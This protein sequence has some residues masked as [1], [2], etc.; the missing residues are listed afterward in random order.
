MCIFFIMCLKTHRKKST[1][2]GTLRLTL[3]AF[4]SDCHFFCFPVRIAGQSDCSCVNILTMSFGETY[5]EHKTNKSSFST[6]C[7]FWQA[8]KEKLHQ[9]C[10]LYMGQA[11]SFSCWCWGNSDLHYENS[12]KYHSAPCTFP[13]C[14]QQLIP[15]NTFA[16]LAQIVYCLVHSILFKVSLLLPPN[17]EVFY[18]LFQNYQI[19][20][21]YGVIYISPL[22]ITDLLLFHIFSWSMSLT[23]SSVYIHWCPDLTFS[24]YRIFHRTFYCIVL[25]FSIFT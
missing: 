8:R 18:F 6:S 9:N 15:V 16:W 5:R 1:T 17:L 3:Q 12:F 24:L 4:P 14:L 22:Y 10:E 20:A 11:Q 7:S 2:D 13:D 19:L 21:G 25:Y 23:L